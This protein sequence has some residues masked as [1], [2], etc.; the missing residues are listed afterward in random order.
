MLREA[1]RDLCARD[2]SLS[3]L[4]TQYGE[5]PLW[6]RPEGFVTLVRM[7]LEQQ[8]SLE[9]AATLF[10]RLNA[11]VAGGMQSGPI[12]A[13]GV[14]GFRALGVT[15][16]K[17]AYLV[18]LA[19]QVTDGRLDLRALATLSD[20]EVLVALQ[21]VPGIGPWTAQVYLLFSLGRPD[22]W[23][24]GDLALHKAL[25]HLHALD[26]VPTSREASQM[27]MAWSP[28]RAVAARILWHAYL[29]QRGR[30]VP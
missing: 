8:V 24:P 11:S 28:W 5:P 12:L 9:S 6:E 26:R 29:T 20:D 13:A 25:Q 22:A 30:S 2:A 4:A 19:E 15:R 7:I 16:Q 10:T 14:D 21:R 3:R 27:A 17:A 18:A 1:V 23:P